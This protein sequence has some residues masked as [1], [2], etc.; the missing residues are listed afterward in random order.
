MRAL[1]GTLHWARWA[2][3]R[4]LL[5]VEDLLSRRAVTGNEHPLNAAAYWIKVGVPAIDG[6]DVDGAKDG[7][8]DANG[9]LANGAMDHSLHH[10]RRPASSSPAA[11]KW[12]KARVKLAVQVLVL[13]EAVA[14][15]TSGV[16][17]FSRRLIRRRRA[18][19]CQVTRSMHPASHTWP[20]SHRSPRKP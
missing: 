14:R 12:R 16:G 13:A 18:K 15:E 6:E 4:K 7:A 10:T 2:L 20:A 1:I 3:E 9:A 8:G 19:T 5:T 11:R 17:R